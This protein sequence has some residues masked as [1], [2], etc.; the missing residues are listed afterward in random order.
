MS[1]RLKV[2]ITQEAYERL[3]EIA[4]QQR[5]SI[6]LQA[7]VILMRALGFPPPMELPPITDASELTR[8]A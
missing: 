3:V 2:A 4:V 5:R 1:V 7:E 8:S 6:D